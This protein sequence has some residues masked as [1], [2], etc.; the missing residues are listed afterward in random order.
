[1]E[2]SLAA[3]G[4][5]AVLSGLGGVGKSTLA[6]HYASRRVRTY[7]PIW[8]ITANNSAGL[9][10]GLAR[11][12]FTLQ[13]ELSQAWPMDESAER[14]TQWLSTHDDWLLIL[15]DVTD[16]AD[17]ASLINRLNCGHIIVTSRLSSRWH[18]INATMI[19]VGPLPRHEALELFTRT[20]QSG[21]PT[22]EPDLYQ[23][24]D[25]VSRLG[26]L[27]LAIRAAA[28]Y[29]SAT[30]IDA[31]EYLHR[32]SNFESDILDLDDSSPARSPLNRTFHASF[33]QLTDAPFALPLLRILS[34]YAHEGI[35]RSLLDNLTLSVDQQTL[36]QTLMKL[37]AHGLLDADATSISMHR[38]LQTFVRTVDPQDPYR[39]PVDITTGLR[40]STELL[41]AALPQ[42]Y[43]PKGWPLWQR[44]IPHITTLADRATS[45]SDTAVS[46]HLFNQAG[47]FLN[48]QGDPTDAI[49]Y[50]MRSHA[51]YSRHYGRLHRDT[52][53]ALGNLAGAYQAAGNL[54][55]ALSLYEQTLAECEQSLGHEDPVVLSTRNDLAGAYLASGDLDAAIPLYE[56]TLTDRERV[57]GDLHPDTLT[58]LN[59]LA[60]AHQVA[61]NIEQSIPLFEQALSKREQVLG[62]QHL[63]TL[64]SRHNL[65]TSLHFVN[66]AGNA[67][68]LLEQ[69][70]ATRERILGSDHPDTLASCNSLAYARLSLGDV[71]GALPLLEE[72]LTDRQRILGSDHPDTLTSLNNLAYAY[73]MKGDLTQAIQLYQS[74]L[75]GCEQFLGSDHPD[76]LAAR[77]NL[78]GAYSTLGELEKAFPLFEQTLTASVRVLGE[79][80]PETFTSRNNLAGAYQGV[81]DLGR[82]IPLYEQTL[83]D[84]VRV[85]GE[86]HPD[87]LTSRNNL[88]GAYMSAGDLGRAIPLYEQTLTASVRV[89]GEDHPSTLTSRSNLAGAYQGAGDLGR[90]I[91]L[92]EQTLT[93]SVRVL[94]ED[95]PSTLTSRNN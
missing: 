17:I 64:A 76:T 19:Q 95:H 83:S 24:A 25:L 4:S 33:E 93:A 10:A 50:H 44:L 7:N 26:G 20:V 86:D 40:Q 23:R 13:P 29:I 37:A 88:A 73:E 61:G 94:G 41:D 56:Q 67:V 15:D 49:P 81:G 57:L 72:T 89:L 30:H 38:L 28:K 71:N 62:D 45:E 47:L 43:E 48:E 68:Q 46:A 5:V 65:A 11:L 53:A 74:T 22:G 9:E 59:N 54:E 27:P 87:T 55:K 60:Y 1:M 84:R 31:A 82:A 6:A 77:S 85:L 34:W 79:D 42:V 36:Q 16:S 58:S 3:P 18:R 52:L 63:D 8:W 21:E 90:A 80:H 12:I 92:Y 78:A 70:L 66:R 14:A 35:P 39:L 32:L 75:A 91:P 69:N 51:A 2:D